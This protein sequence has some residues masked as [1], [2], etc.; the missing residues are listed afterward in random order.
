MTDRFIRIAI[1][2][3][4]VA[5][6]LALSISFIAGSAA[7]ALAGESDEGGEDQNGPRYCS[8]IPA[9]STVT[10]TGGNA[11]INVSWSS[12]TGA[13]GYDVVYSLAGSDSESFTSFSSSVTSANITSSKITNGNT[14]SVQVRAYQYS[15]GSDVADCE[16]TLSSAVTVIMPPNPPTNV[17]ISIETNDDNDLDVTFTRSG[18]VHNYQIELHSAG[19]EHGI[20][21][22]V[23]TANVTTSPAN[24]DDQTREY[25]YKARARN[26]NSST[27]TVCGGWSPLTDAVQ[28]PPASTTTVTTPAAPSNL[29]LSVETNDD[30]DL[31]VSF[32]RT[33]SI[34]F[35]QIEL[36]S[37]SNQ[38]GIYS[39]VTSANVTASPVDF[40]NQAREHWYK[41]RGKNCSTSARTTCT[42]W[43]GWSNAARILPASTTTTPPIT[44]SPTPTSTPNTP[45]PP[46]NLVATRDASNVLNV[47]V[48]YTRSTGTVHFYEIE[49][50]RSTTENGTYVLQ[51]AEHDSTSSPA[52]F[53]L[54]P[55][56]FWFKA[57]GRNCNTAERIECGDWSA[58]S[59][60]IAPPT[61]LFLTNLS[62]SIEATE[63]ASVSG[64]AFNLDPLLRYSIRVTTTTGGDIGFNSDCTDTQED[65]TVSAGSTFYNFRV[66]PSLYGCDPGDGT[67]NVVLLSGGSTVVN[68]T[69]KDLTVTPPSMI[70]V[71]PQNPYAGQ[72]VTM[73]ATAPTS[74]GAVT[75]YRW[76]EFSGGQWSN[77]TST[78]TSQSVPSNAISSR[79]FKVEA[80]YTS[81]KKEDSAW[82]LV[83]WKP[84]TVTVTASPDNPVSGNATKRQVTLTAT[85]DAPSGVTYQWQQGS[86]NTWTNLD[87]ATTS[88]TKTVSFS[89]RGTRKFKVQVLHATASSGESEA[90]YVTWDEW[91]ILGDMATALTTAVTGDA[92]YISA[93][94]ALVTCINTASPVPTTLFSSFDGI[95]DNYTGATKTKMDSGGACSSQATT[96]FTRNQDLHRSKMATLK[97]GSS[98][99]AILYAGLLETPRGSQFEANV[100]DSDTLKRLA[101]F[102][103]TVGTPGSLELPLYVPSN[104]RRI[105][106]RPT[107]SVVQ[108]PGLDCLPAGVN[109][110]RL[111]LRNKLLVLNCLIFD[112]PHSFWV[113]GDASSREAKQLKREIDSPTGRYAWLK[114]G[115]WECSSIAPAGPVPSCLKHDVAYASLQKFAGDD[116]D[117]PL[118]NE[119]DGNEL[120]EAWNPRNKALADEK[121]RADILKHGCQDQS[122]EYAAS[123][124][125]I[126][127]RGAIAGTFHYGVAEKNHKGWPVTTADID[128]FTSNYRF[129]VC[130]EPVV[131]TVSGLAVS[132]SG[133]TITASW[134]FEPGCVP[135]AL[136]DV[137]FG[138]TW[139]YLDH[140]DDGPEMTDPNSSSCTVSGNRVTCSY[141]FNYLRQLGPILAGVSIFVIPDEKKYGGNDYGGEGNTGR[142]YTANIGPVEF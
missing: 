46:S 80:T 54:L 99:N 63:T 5:T 134:D 140:A 42:G 78:T 70:S 32:T 33:G 98:A 111:T 37:S 61:Y 23:T 7:L 69:H 107:P 50:H 25:W 16:G 27:R 118:A 39:R 97:S 1:R 139:D 84:I 30:N 47:S 18:S 38:N 101:Y 108:R 122:G 40:D 65:I 132:K 41:A 136:G 81:G 60:A 72:S 12:V 93:Q 6:G 67:V 117:A 86:G 77:L 34:H 20:Y 56:Q 96:M 2:W 51:A 17:S 127:T 88:T 92:T 19:S 102:G 29:N 52:I 94:T 112:T 21:S 95:L 124:C 8:P 141:N 119:P 31:D 3:L 138:V 49:L 129:K 123:V 87:A 85:A 43:S 113:K 83:R 35:Y 10:A 103:A 15:S 71:V 114:R 105:P 26:C 89:T 90:I 4:I 76:Q 74:R 59:S 75:S 53:R 91:A 135:I 130:N 104:G 125:W 106:T 66:V 79:I 24:F 142:R 62:S 126:S 11:Q 22:L 68:A 48:A 14:Y 131:P 100:A 36:H 57:R 58:W 133:D 28:I 121:F 45:A 55:T 128:D 64:W 9:P 120:D 13:D 82:V 115:D 44:P 110:A 109:G 73:T 137:L 116:A